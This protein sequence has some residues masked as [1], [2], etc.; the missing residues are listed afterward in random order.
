LITPELFTDNIKLIHARFNQVYDLGVAKS[1][2]SI[3]S[4]DLNDELFE[5]A[6]RRVLEE[7]RFFPS[8][9]QIREKVL[10]SPQQIAEADWKQ[11]VEAAHAATVPALTKASLEAVRSL[12]GFR[13]FA[14]ATQELRKSFLD[15]FELNW[16]L[17]KKQGLTYTQMVEPVYPVVRTLPA[18]LPQPEYGPP[19]DPTRLRSL[20]ESWEIAKR[21]RSDC[22][23]AQA[24]KS[25][26]QRAM[27]LRDAAKEN[28]VDL[29]EI[30]GLQPGSHWTYKIE[31]S[32][33]PDESLFKNSIEPALRSLTQK[34]SIDP[35]GSTHSAH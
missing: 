4:E 33:A 21:I 29:S 17:L 30:L 2:Y 3:L 12:G 14:D 23:R 16:D 11:L 25:L 32:P 1:Y 10:P 19:D 28:D 6:C 15:L 22:V 5:R 31:E 24:F 35:N 8:P 13:S 18:V 27:L 26:R 20:L 9:K 7:D 34:L